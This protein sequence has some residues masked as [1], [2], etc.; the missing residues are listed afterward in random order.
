LI[1]VFSPTPKE[2]SQTDGWTICDDGEETNS[3][4]SPDKNP[5]AHQPPNQMTKNEEGPTSFDGN[6][7]SGP[8]RRSQLQPLTTVLLIWT[9]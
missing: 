4:P 3:Q 5:K 6:G 7:G 1:P 8:V 9:I 2:F